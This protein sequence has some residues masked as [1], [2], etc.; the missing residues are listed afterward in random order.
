MRKKDRKEKH[1]RQRFLKFY[2]VCLYVNF[3][4]TKV[5]FSITRNSKMV[6]YA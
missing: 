3:P 6:A 2:I 1:F 4:H 5:D